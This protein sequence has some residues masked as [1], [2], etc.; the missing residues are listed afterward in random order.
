MHPRSRH[1]QLL[2]YVLVRQR[3]RQDVMMIKAIYD[4][5]GWTDQ[6]LVI[7][8][9]RPGLQPRRRPRDKRPPGKLNTD[10]LSLPAHHLHFGNQ[11]TLRLED[12]PIED[13][14]VS[15]ETQWCQ[16]QDAVHSIALGVLDRA[17]RQHQDFFDDNDAVINNLL[18]EKNRLHR[19]YLDRP[20]NAA[21]LRSND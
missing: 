15:V 7:P 12:L 19:A 10:L 13:E 6:R 2:D 1:S 21:V 17:R 11:L 20:T 3:N 8:K 16:L 4:A 18:A 9:M 14:N 5:D